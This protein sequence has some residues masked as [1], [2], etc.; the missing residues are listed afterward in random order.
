MRRT[1][2]RDVGVLGGAFAVVFARGLPSGG[3]VR[4]HKE[5]H[6]LTSSSLGHSIG[7]D[8]PNCS[9]I[10]RWEFAS[11]LPHWN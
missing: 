4:C 2:R 8:V 7:Q 1:L 5:R 3:S 6:V 9:A 10:D 11:I